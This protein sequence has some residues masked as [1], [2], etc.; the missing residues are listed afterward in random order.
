[1]K[2]VTLDLAPAT[3]DADGIASL[4]D[5]SGTSIILAGALVSNGVFTSSDGL[6]RIIT[7]TD[8]NADTQ[9]DVTFTVV[10]TNTNND[11]ISEAITGPGA[12]A[13]VASTKYFKTVSSVTVSAAQGGTEAVNIGT[14]NTTL[15]A[16]SV[17]VPL[18]FYDEVAP[19]ISVDVTGTINFTVQQTFDSILTVK[20]SS[21]GI[22]WESIT[23]LTAKTAD[24]VAQTSIGAKAIRV[25]INSYS[26]SA[27]AQVAIIS[28]FNDLLDPVNNIGPAVTV[29]S[30]DKVVIRDVSD[31]DNLRTATAQSVADLA[32]IGT[33][34]N[35]NA[36]AGSGGE[37][38]S[39][40]VLFASR[41]SITSGT[42][43]NITFIN[44]TAGDWNVGGSVG[45]FGA[46]G[47]TVTYVG[48]G[49]NTTSATVPDSAYL[50]IIP[51]AGIAPYAVS[52]ITLSVP[53]Q[54]ISIASTT[55][56]YLVGVTVFGVSTTSAYGQI[57]ARRAR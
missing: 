37:V 53:T 1:M 44:L 21:G 14:R 46:A 32:K 55:T 27:T 8:L 34:T 7:I 39:S 45:F 6:G 54:R 16:V 24:T 51:F 42:A 41:A 49:I 38:I 11:A 50:G 36:A 48:G 31:S 25:L 26:A 13:T 3:L 22:S 47:T 23:A 5:A 52:E 28:S 30:A 33:T 43:K 18:D 20:D 10:G 57:I 29:V 12:N 2:T 17:V 56:V 4:A 40:T 35:D 9:T 19:E 15:S